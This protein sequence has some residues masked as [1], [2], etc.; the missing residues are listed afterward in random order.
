[1]VMKLYIDDA[2]LLY[3]TMFNISMDIYFAFSLTPYP[4]FHDNCHLLSHLL[5]YFATYIAN[6][7]DPD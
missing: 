1:M 7:M 3:Y 4:A 6:N 2:F 5:M